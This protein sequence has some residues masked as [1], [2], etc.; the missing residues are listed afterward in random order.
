M[1]LTVTSRSNQ[2]KISGTEECCVSVVNYSF[3]QWK[4]EQDLADLNTNSIGPSTHMTRTGSCK[5][6]HKQMN[7]N[8][9]LRNMSQIR[10]I[11]I[12]DVEL[13]LP[14]PSCCSTVRWKWSLAPCSWPEFWPTTESTRIRNSPGT[15]WSSCEIRRSSGWKCDGC[16]LIDQQTNQPKK[17]ERDQDQK[18]LR[19]SNDDRQDETFI[20]R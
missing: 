16:D 15:R 8:V 11:D 6:V 20:S 12:V 19:L 4:Q 18:Q 7:E 17:M 9:K 14:F 3:L 10:I 2:S 5:S 13:R 1:P